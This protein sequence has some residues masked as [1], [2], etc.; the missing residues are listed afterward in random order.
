MVCWH[1][2]RRVLGL[3]FD[4]YLVRV[5][6]VLLWRLNEVRIGLFTNVHCGYWVSLLIAFLIAVHGV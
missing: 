2:Q 3:R 5:Y 6:L 1:G 4:D